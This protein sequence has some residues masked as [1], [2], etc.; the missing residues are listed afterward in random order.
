MARAPASAVGPSRSAAALVALLVVLC[1]QRSCAYAGVFS[2]V[3]EFAGPEAARHGGDV[4]LTN[5]VRIRP[6][7]FQRFMRSIRQVNPTVEVVVFFAEIDEDSSHILRTFGGKFVVFNESALPREEL[8][9]ETWIHRFTLWRMF[10][11]ARGPDVYKRVFLC[12]SRD[13]VFFGDP[14]ARLPDNL[15]QQVFLCD[16][17]VGECPWNTKW[18]LEC[19]GPEMQ[20]AL[21]DRR[22]AIGGTNVG[23]YAHMLEY[24]RTQERLIG[25]VPCRTSA[26]DNVIL[27]ALLWNGHLREP[28]ILDNSRS[29][30]GTLI[31]KGNFT[32]DRFGRPTNGGLV[33]FAALHQYDRHPW[34]VD[35]I[36]GMYP[37]DPELEKY[38]VFY[39]ALQQGDQG[40]PQW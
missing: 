14:F 7:L 31:Y 13:V 40:K 27:N 12:D 6:E 39:P 32:R 37:Y 19:F 16:A 22:M 5:H 3:D 4:I 8:P 30:L 26:R 35:M 28:E 34:L 11:E 10:L 29:W 9:H 25:Q 38:F 20:A 1:V 24:C 33:P 21:K 18:V 23:T 15:T 36:K 2:Q 17:T